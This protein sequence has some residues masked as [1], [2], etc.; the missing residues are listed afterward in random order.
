MSRSPTPIESFGPEILAA[1]IAGATK[2]VRVKTTYG[3]A[4]KF[5]QRAHQ[6][7]NIMREESHP[8][9][10]AV[11]RTRIQILYGKAA[12]F[13]QVEESQNTKKV[14]YPKDPNVDAFLIISPQDSEFTT[15]LKDAGVEVK[16]P[17][18]EELLPPTTSD[19]TPPQ[20]EDVL[21]NFLNQ[22]VKK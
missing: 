14:R 4:V 2:E 17:S 8:K 22:D 3:K 5:R 6:L 12:G 13:A 1:L 18:D 20:A 10:T 11:A 15:A 19:E 21:Q 16:I 7:R 9:Y